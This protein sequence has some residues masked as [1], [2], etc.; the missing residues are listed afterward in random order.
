MARPHNCTRFADQAGI[1]LSSLCLVHCLLTPFILLG[2]PALSLFKLSESLH[3]ALAI[4]LP[5][6]ALVAFVPGFRRHHQIRVLVLGA[7]GLLLIIGAALFNAQLAPALEALITI[8]GSLLL[9]RAHVLNRNY[10]H[11]H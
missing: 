4:I 5:A 10:C 9:V 8:S 1:W 7:I 3:E 6:I 2:L 11:C